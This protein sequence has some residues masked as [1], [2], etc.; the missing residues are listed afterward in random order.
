MCPLKIVNVT[1]ISVCV[2]VNC[3]LALSFS[4]CLLCI[5]LTQFPNLSSSVF[6]FFAQ[7]D[8]FSHLFLFSGLET[9]IQTQNMREW[10]GLDI[11]IQFHNDETWKYD[12]LLFLTIINLCD[13]FD[14]DDDDDDADEDNKDDNDY[15]AQE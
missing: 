10:A 1:N 6:L 2:C 9:R 7:L 3:F 13:V 5:S 15:D 12:D 14:N 11:D 4:P 8:F